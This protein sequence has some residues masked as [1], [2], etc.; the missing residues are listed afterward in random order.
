MGGPAGARAGP[1]SAGGHEQGSLAVLSTV[2]CGGFEQGSWGT[3]FTE[4]AQSQKDRERE[5]RFAARL[6]AIYGTKGRR[7][8]PDSRW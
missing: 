7:L 4:K 3:R 1:D 2:L 8:S 5:R 6:L